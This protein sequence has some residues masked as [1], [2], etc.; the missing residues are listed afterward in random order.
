MTP[1][2]IAEWIRVAPWLAATCA[3]VWGAVWTV[4]KIA[5]VAR[6]LG[7][8]VDDL[9][10]EPERPGVPAR[11][12]LMERMEAVETK[13]EIIRHEMYPNS[14]KSLRDKL[15]QTSAA[16]DVLSSDITTINDKLDQ[17][18]R[19]LGEVEQ[20][21]TDAIKIIKEHHP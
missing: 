18:N 11:P 9:V 4:R 20:K 1:A 19:R 8:L 10:G 16:V 14:G 2:E 21:V 17:D 15:D 3:V 6:K 7:H 12:G 5:P 13:A